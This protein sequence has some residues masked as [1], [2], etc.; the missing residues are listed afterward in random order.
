MKNNSTTAIPRFYVDHAAD[1]SHGGYSVVTKDNCIKQTAA[2][3]RYAFELP[4]QEVVEFVVVEEVTF[5]TPCSIR[6]FL[7]KQSDEWLAAG[8]L[9][10]QDRKR[11]YDDVVLTERNSILDRIASVST[12]IS[13]EDL[14]R[15]RAG[16][17]IHPST[18]TSVTLVPDAVL[19]SLAEL[20][21]LKASEATAKLD[22]ARLESQIQQVF[23]NQERLRENIKSLE[24]V[25]DNPLLR[26]YLSDLDKEEDDLIRARKSIGDLTL[27][28]QKLTGDMQALRLTAAT[29]A[30]ALRALRVVS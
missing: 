20:L 13:E 4:P 2:F 6:D 1:V 30:K 15:W 24:K 7:S 27:D 12:T 3:A 21:R 17:V 28:I 19:E 16:V 18:G 23:K 5:V 9:S 11:V 10:P 8:L 26:R 22:V 29:A 25:G 14:R